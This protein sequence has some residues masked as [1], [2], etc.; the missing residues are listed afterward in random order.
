[1][2]AVAGQHRRFGAACAADRGDVDE[3]HAAP[4]A[5]RLRGGVERVEQ[6]DRVRAA[7]LELGLD[8]RT[9]RALSGRQG[10]AADLLR[11][12]WATVRNSPALARL[13]ASE[14]VD[15]IHAHHPVGAFQA[16]RAGKQARLVLH[17]HE[18]LPAP[19]QYLALAGWLRDRCDAFVCV[20][21]AGREMLRHLGIPEEK[22]HLV[23]NAV[24]AAFLGSPRP[25]RLGPG[26]HIG[27]FGVLEPRKGH[28]ELITALARLARS[29]PN[30]QLWI[31]GELTYARN[32][33]YLD[34]L[35][36][37]AAEWHVADRIH[38][39]GYRQDIP[40][41]MAAMDVVA[42]ASRELESLPTVLLEA[43]ALGRVC[44]A[45][46]VGGVREIIE[47]GR[48]GLVVR[49]EHAPELADALA[50][51]LSP[52]AAGMARAARARARARFSPER[53]EGD[54]LSVFGEVLRARQPAA[55]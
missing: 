24:G 51:A 28:A 10:A 45:T 42:L 18:T 32:T 14:A 2:Q 47:H 19:R 20:S 27:V 41:L 16:V 15:L 31:V 38:F 6:D 13:V 33:A 30:A 21:N 37:L 39:L 52:V 55:H 35:K 23:Y 46:D 5:Q 1:M 34:E 9:I 54:L 29:E 11:G 8:C 49:P 43:S 26:P 3:G 25:V 40:E 7:A 50:I 22:I 53:F 48:T 4:G 17:V 44:V 36:S 12:A